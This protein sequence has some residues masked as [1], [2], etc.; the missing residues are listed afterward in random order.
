MAVAGVAAGH[1]AIEEVHAAG[2]GLDDVAGSADAHQ[3]TDLILGHIGLDRA[4]HLVHHLSGLTHSEAA[5]GVA[6]QVQVSDLLHVLHAQ[7]GEGAALIDAEEQ[8]VGV[9]GDAFMLQAGHLILAALE[10][11]GGA[12]AAGFGVIMLGGVLDALI[13]GHGDGRAKVCLD[14]HTFL[15]THEDAVAVEVRGKGHAL[16]GDLAQLCEA[17]HLKSA[18]VGKDGAVPAGKL[19]QTAHLCHQLVA[20]T[21]MQMVGVAE[22]DLRTNVLQ[23]MGR[24]AALDG[25]GGGNILER[26]GLHRAVYGLELAPP[27]IVLLLEQLVGRQR[28]HNI[29][30]F[31]A[32]KTAVHP[33]AGGVCSRCGYRVG[34]LQRRSAIIV[35]RS[36]SHRQS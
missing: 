25:A 27:G 15:R 14:L 7:V 3:V 28:R 5:D 24:Q 30:P 19:V 10:P 32:R 22:H 29:F 6:V 36:A 21:Q 26:G 8:L 23:V 1:D 20:G 18:A 13:K 17:E 33:A 34:I 16:L 9:D 2:D 4:D 12:L 35:T 11:A 31:C